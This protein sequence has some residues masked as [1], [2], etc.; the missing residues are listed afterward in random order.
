MTFMGM[1]FMSSVS[2]VASH[3]V[4]DGWGG[5]GVMIFM[6]IRRISSIPFIVSYIVGEGGGGMGDMTSI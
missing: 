1:R 3:T 2:F 5:D 4:G 6:G